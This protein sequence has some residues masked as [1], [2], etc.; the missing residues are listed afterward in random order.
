[1]R[2]RVCCTNMK[3]ELLIQYRNA[4][5][6]QTCVKGKWKNC[7]TEK[8]VLNLLMYQCSFS[9]VM[10]LYKESVKT[11]TYTKVEIVQ[12]GCGDRQDKIG[13]WLVEVGEPER[14]GTIHVL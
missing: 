5:A 7:R 8:K 4:P 11:W 13:V 12:K 1:M 10:P 3:L 2:M 6:G 9:L 14:A